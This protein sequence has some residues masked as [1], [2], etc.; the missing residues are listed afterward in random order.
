MAEQPEVEDLRRRMDGALAS[1]KT[2]FVGLRTG[3]ASAG[4]LEPVMVD[5]YG[6]SMPLNQVATISVPE[7]R[8]LV[9]QV[10]DRGMAGAVDKAIRNSGLGLNPITE[11]QVIRV[12]VPEL[13]EQRRVE[14]GKVAARYA[15]QARVAVRNVRRDGMEHLKKREKDG[16]LGQDEHKRLSE[17]VQKLTDEMIH[18]VDETL[19]AKEREIMQI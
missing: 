17:R 14:L 4:M 8:M 10:W 11:G 5:A 6:S 12:P 16:D 19:A 18:K 1:L 2:E 15:E 3:R 7:P 13:S 9:V